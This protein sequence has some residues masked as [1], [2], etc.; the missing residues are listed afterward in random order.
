MHF[1]Y[2]LIYNIYVNIYHVS[3]KHSAVY[4]PLVCLA[5]FHVLAIVNNAAINIRCRYLFETVISFPSDK[6]PEVE[7]P[8]LPYY[9]VW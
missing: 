1:L 3:I 9:I 8:E 7:Y 6:Y 4:E 2:A 5:C